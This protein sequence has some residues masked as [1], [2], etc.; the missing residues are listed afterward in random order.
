MRRR[1]TGCAALALALATAPPAAGRSLEEIL[2]DKGILDEG[3]VEELETGRAEREPSAATPSPIP[4]WVS[5]ITPFG[6]VRVRNETFLRSG[7]RDR[8]RQRFRL[9]LGAR[10]KLDDEAELGFRL[11]TGTDG[12][13]TS[14]NQTFTDAFT[15]KSVNL[16]AAYLALSP[17]KSLGWSR[18]YLKLLGGKY[19]VPLYGPPTPTGLVFDRDLTPEGFFESLKL[20]E[21]DLG[22]LRA[23]GVNL[24]QWVFQESSRTGDGALFAFQASASLAPAPGVAWNVGAGDLL[25]QKESTIAAARNSNASLNVTNDVRLSDGTVAGGRPVDPSRAGPAGDGLD[26]AGNPI[27]I[28]GYVSDFN[29]VNAGT[30]ALIDTGRPAWPVRLFGDWALNTEAAGG[31]DS[32]YEVGAALGRSKERNDVAVAY[33][34]EHLETNAVI[35][36][37]S[38]SDFGRDGGTN[39][40]GHVLQV[41]YVFLEGVTLL[42]TAYITEPIDH[43][44][45]R[46]TTTDYRWQLDL[47][48][49][50]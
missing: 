13:L 14:T 20:V 24:G 4:D 46:S 26:A 42:S 23:A 3:E 29:V 10:A 39:T 30:D 15:F 9:R 37:F 32:G 21:R 35:S 31:E 48:G 2:R 8:V 34:W 1:W 50:F 18:P 49:R 36:A 41:S 25:F 27:R 47:V 16:S 33:A 28:L 5:R 38:E 45:G 22:L 7:D 12:E 19:D 44:S 6:D 40:E 17:A 43:V 11:A